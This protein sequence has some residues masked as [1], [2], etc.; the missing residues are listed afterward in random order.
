MSAPVATSSGQLPG[1]RRRIASMAYEGLLLIGVLSVTFMLP[2]LAIGMAFGIIFPGWVL[3]T[4]VFVVLSA[5]FI[6]YW[7]HGG[8]TLAMQTWKIQLSTPGGEQP[9]LARLVL[10][11][12]LAWP[13]I[14]Y[15]GVGVLWA[16]FDRDHQFLHDRLAGT[17]IVFKRD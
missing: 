15:F 14:V 7:H 16:L 12:V 11:Y 9:P 3:I 1:L 2:H 10:R 13:S 4:H 8:Q 17:R 6:W 5:Y